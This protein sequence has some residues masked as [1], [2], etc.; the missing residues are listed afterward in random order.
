MDSTIVEVL[1]AYFYRFL[2]ILSSR[3]DVPEDFSTDIGESEV[4]TVEAVR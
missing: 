1:T 3:D 2:R 4:A